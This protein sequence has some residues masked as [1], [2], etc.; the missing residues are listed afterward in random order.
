MAGEVN[1]IGQSKRG[2][3]DR[4]SRRT[5]LQ[6]REKAEGAVSLDQGRD[7]AADSVAVV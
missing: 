4:S 2:G 1:T 7:L 6:A 5:Q 3:G